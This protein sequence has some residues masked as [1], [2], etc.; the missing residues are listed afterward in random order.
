MIK[1]KCVQEEIEQL[2]HERHYHS[3]PR[4]RQRMEVVYLKALGYQHKEIGR[5]VKI[6]QKTLRN[7]LQMYQEGGI[8]ELKVL[9]FHQ[10][11]SELQAHREKLEKEF[12]A[13]PPKTINEAD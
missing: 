11:V 4:V 10:P 2:H 6:N 3:H 13:H 12:K 8:E 9:R 1:F 5:V 7:Y